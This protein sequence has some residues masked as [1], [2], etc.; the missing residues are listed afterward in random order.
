MKNISLKIILILFVIIFSFLNINI[1]ADDDKEVSTKVNIEDNINEIS[2]LDESY[3]EV[4]KYLEILR[5]EVKKIDK[6]VEGLKSNDEY[7]FY[8]AIRLNIDTPIFGLESL[9]EQ[10]LKIKSEVSA[11]EIAQGYS[12]RD[13]IT[14]NSIKIPNFTIASN[15]I[16]STKNVKIDENITKEDANKVVLK[17]V[18]Y[19]NQVKDIHD[20]V[21]KQSNNIF[22]GYVDKN[23]VNTIDDLN[24]RLNKLSTDLVNEEKEITKIK[25][26]LVNNEKYELYINEYNEL[27]KKILN[28]KKEISNILLSDKNLE[29][30]KKETEE[31]ETK[32]AE[33]SKDIDNTLELAKQE[34][35]IN[36]M[37]Q[38]LKQELVNY[39]NE[40]NKY[41]VDNSKGKVEENI[42]I[43]EDDETKKIDDNNIKI[44][45]TD[46]EVISELQNYINKLDDDIN[47]YINCDYDNITLEEKIKI[48]DN[49]TNIYNDFLNKVYKFYLDNLDLLNKNNKENIEYITRNNDTVS[50]NSIEYTYMYLCDKLEK[51]QNINNV[52]TFTGK[53]NLVNEIKQELINVVKINIETND[54]YNK[55][56]KNS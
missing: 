36:N 44:N 25:I 29:E 51:I 40:I 10:K 52:N 46:S 4:K 19:I 12:I 20:F 13:I 53:Q 23:K 41:I 37:L 1:Y 30:C 48:L 14:N 16:I 43:K 8:P 18:E 31:L 54:I 33:Y 6:I 11:V 5:V 56:S 24:K 32:I 47:K 55:L 34:M 35:N 49:V 50:F 21:D 17:L 38:T 26:S 2:D 7:N 28:I 42:E 22:N 3:K 15:I 39:K 45:I 27:N 9:I